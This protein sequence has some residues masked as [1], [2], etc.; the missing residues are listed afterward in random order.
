[1]SKRFKSCGGVYLSQAAIRATSDIPIGGF[2]YETDNPAGE[3]RLYM[4]LPIEE[5]YLGEGYCHVVLGGEGREWNKN[6]EKPTVEG[7]IQLMGRNPLE[8]LWHGYLKDGI[9][10]ACE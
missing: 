8:T 7:S 1:M 4:R 5:R 10:E 9:F 2:Y 3:L 6:R